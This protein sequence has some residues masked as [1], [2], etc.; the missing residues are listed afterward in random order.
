MSV[1]DEFTAVAKLPPPGRGT[2]EVALDPPSLLARAWEFVTHPNNHRQAIRFLCVGG[3]GY[4]V[5]LVC[6]AVFL[7]VFGIQHTVA[8]WAASLCGTVNN[9][10]W[11]R[12]WT[13]SDSAHH[14]IGRQGVRF[15]IVS[16]SVA[17]LAYAVYLGIVAT[18]GIDKVLAEALAYIIVTPFSFVAQKLWSFR[19]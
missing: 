17:A 3:S 15:L 2:P 10:W 6:F 8:F 18:V 13:F 1:T 16:A 12:S 5:N 7:H 19:A 11:N 4:V 9:F 14:H